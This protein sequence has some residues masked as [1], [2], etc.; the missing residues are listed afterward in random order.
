M[1][2]GEKKLST[3]VRPLC[4]RPSHSRATSV[5]VA[6]ATVIASSL[7]FECGRGL[8]LMRSVGSQLASV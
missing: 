8:P 3:P 2:G 1:C 5:Y 7:S 6:S 4:R